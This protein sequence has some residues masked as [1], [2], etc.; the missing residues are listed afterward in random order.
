MMLL[1][2]KRRYYNITILAHWRCFAKTT[3]RNG[4]ERYKNEHIHKPFQKQTLAS[5]RDIG[6]SKEKI[7]LISE[8]EKR[9]REKEKVNDDRQ[10]GRH[11]YVY[12]GQQ[13]ALHA[14]YFLYVSTRTH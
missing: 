3:E 7:Q 4:T 1:C 6:K 10:A 13:F 14:L 11:F 12:M 9:E 5:V 2:R 8:S